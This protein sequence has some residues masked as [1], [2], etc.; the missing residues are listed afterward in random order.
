MCVLD[1]FGGATTSVSFLNRS[2]FFVTSSFSDV[3][4]S[5]ELGIESE[6]LKVPILI[7]RNGFFVLVEALKPANVSINSSIRSLS[8]YESFTRYTVLSSGIFEGSSFKSALAPKRA[9]L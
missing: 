1:S 2:F 4:I 7:D 8:L 5:S 6:E 3:E 9:I